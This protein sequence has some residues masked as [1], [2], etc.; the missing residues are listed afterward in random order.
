MS[1][2]PPR[3]TILFSLFWLVFVL[4][5]FS[6]AAAHY[7]VVAFIACVFV[8][9]GLSWL[10]RA[11]I[12]LVT[13]L[14]SRQHQSPQSE[15]RWKLLHPGIELA[16]MELSLA[17]IFFNIP[18]GIRLK[19]SESALTNY[20]QEV[21]AG[22]R[23]PQHWGDPTRRVGLFDVKETELLGGG[24]VRVITAEDFIDHAGLV[25]SPQQTPPIRGE[26]T[27]RHLYGAWWHWERSW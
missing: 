14:R 18:L 4:I 1:V 8:F 12:L 19:L 20:V 24:I 11:I 17:L 9:W 7:L 13:V 25:Y 23:S 15:R 21:R 16:A 2:F 6:D 10:V 27:Y 22:R 3:L 26:D 5:S